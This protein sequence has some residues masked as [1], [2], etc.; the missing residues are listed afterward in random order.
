[1]KKYFGSEEFSEGDLEQLARAL[2]VSRREA[3]PRLVKKP[4]AARE[5]ALEASVDRPH[6]LD[7]LEDVMNEYAE[8]TVD[9]KERLFVCLAGLDRICDEHGDGRNPMHR[10]LFRL[11]VGEEEREPPFPDPPLDI[12]LVAGKP[13]TPICYLSQEHGEQEPPLKT[14]D[15]KYYSRKSQTGR[16]LKLWSEVRKFDWSARGNLLKIRSRGIDI[17][18][19]RDRRIARFFEW[20][21]KT[22]SGSRSSRITEPHSVRRIQ[23]ELWDS[24]SL[25]AVVM[26]AWAETRSDPSLTVGLTHAI[27]TLESGRSDDATLRRFMEGLDQ[28]VTTD[29]SHGVVRAVLEK[30]REFDEQLERRQ[31]FSKLDTRGLYTE[32][33]NSPDSE[34]CDLIL[35]HLALFGLPVEPYVIFGCPQVIGRLRHLYNAFEGLKKRLEGEGVLE[36]GGEDEGTPQRDRRRELKDWDERVWMLTKQRAQLERLCERN[37]VIQL[38]PSKAPDEAHEDDPEEA[39][40]GCD[41][42]FLHRRYV[43]HARLREHFAHLVELR[44]LDRSD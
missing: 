43:L 32:T 34:L 24:M 27:G 3:E 11:L 25:T 22:D 16:M 4:E 23:R 38:M 9:T 1:M 5:S 15:F 29:G 44:M 36:H 13:R 40:D 17:E 8:L 42:G 2:Y 39:D 10:A 7:V 20:L 18:Q 33:S 31:D 35:R 21:E 28:A 26:A 6:R 12:V 41:V 14:A 30:Y 37:L 19:E